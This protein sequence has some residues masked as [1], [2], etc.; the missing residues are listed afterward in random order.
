MFFLIIFVYV[1]FGQNALVSIFDFHPK[2]VKVSSV[3]V[4]SI[5][6]QK[7]ERKL[8]NIMRNVLQVRAFLEHDEVT[9]DLSPLESYR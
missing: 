9:R 7:E 6:V 2:F 4:Q 3:Y 5:L 1:S 8:D